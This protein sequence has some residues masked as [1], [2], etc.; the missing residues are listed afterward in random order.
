[1]NEE[2]TIKSSNKVKLD[3]NLVCYS[4]AIQYGLSIL[5]ENKLKEEITRNYF[6]LSDF[7]A[8]N[9]RKINNAKGQFLH[10]CLD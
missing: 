10:I 8:C 6:S 4:L 3:Y 1:M 9:N 2:T 5:E 7:L